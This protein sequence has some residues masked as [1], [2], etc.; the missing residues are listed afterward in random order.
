MLQSSVLLRC[1]GLSIYEESAAVTGKQFVAAKA[2]PI[3][4]AA[5]CAVT[6]RPNWG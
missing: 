4:L 3:K 1:L 2:W 5:L 6:Q